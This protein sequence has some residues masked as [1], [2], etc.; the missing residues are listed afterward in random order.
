[1][2]REKTSSLRNALSESEIQT[3][4][5][6]FLDC[7]IGSSAQI[8]SFMGSFQVL[9]SAKLISGYYEALDEIF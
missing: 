3:E 8:F 1:M 2:L 5:E 9:F 7:Q 4:R 6:Y